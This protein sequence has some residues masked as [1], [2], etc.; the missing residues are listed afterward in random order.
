MDFGVREKVALVVGASSGIGLSIAK[1]LAAEGAKVV[2]AARRE[3]PLISAV[4]DIRE[5]GGDAAYVCADM[6]DAEQV[7]NAV[8]EARRQFGSPDIA[9]ANVRPDL[10]FRFRLTSDEQFRRVYDQLV[11]SV[12]FLTRA[13]T[14]HMVEKKWGRII[15][16]GSV[17]AKEPHRWH[18]LILSNTGRTAQLGLG[19][20][21][22]NEFSEFGIT[23]N[24]MAI[25]LIDTG[26]FESIKSTGDVDEVPMYEEAPRITLGRPGRPDEVAALC[27]F[28]ASERASYIT[29]QVISVD[30]GWTRGI[31]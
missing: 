20:S 11:M 25:G 5:A 2:L 10:T 30:G 18:N 8:S 14:P 28:L 6:T 7:E 19:R 4:E 21:I 31:F 13:V 23:Y 22:S 1:E 16:V 17:C 9:I 29:G 27:A 26:I 24:T 12:V 3:Q 15:N